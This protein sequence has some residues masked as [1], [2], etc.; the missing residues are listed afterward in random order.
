MDGLEGDCL[1]LAKRSHLMPTVNWWN[2]KN[3]GALVTAQLALGQGCSFLVRGS[4][5][6]RWP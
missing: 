3:F 5:N 1:F 6:I 2:P 4:L